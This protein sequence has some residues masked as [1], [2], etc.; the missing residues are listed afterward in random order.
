MP[1]IDSRRR[2]C[3]RP[4]RHLVASSGCCVVPPSS[5]WPRSTACLQ[6]LTATKLVSLYVTM[7]SGCMLK[8][9][10]SGSHSLPATSILSTGNLNTR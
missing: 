7:H 8:T 1:G 6:R 2:S 4:R 3:R 9:V 10:V 5:P